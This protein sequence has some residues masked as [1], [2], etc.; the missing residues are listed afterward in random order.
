[1]EN[2]ANDS[3]PEV[4]VEREDEVLKVCLTF[5]R[6]LLAPCYCLFL[7]KHDARVC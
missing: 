7:I 6:Q 3:N 4:T 2:K 5:T 1:M